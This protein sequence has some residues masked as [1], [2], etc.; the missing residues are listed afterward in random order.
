MLIHDIGGE[1]A[2]IQRLGDI[3][4][5]CGAE[6]LVGIGDDAAVIRGEGGTFLLVTTDTLVSGDHFNTSWS[7]PE[8][9]GTKAA[10]PRRPAYSTALKRHR[11]QDSL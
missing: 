7:R 11:S 8:Q 2:L 4:P 3:V 5:S 1:F 10:S 9:I 6:V